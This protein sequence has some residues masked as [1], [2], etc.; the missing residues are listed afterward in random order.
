MLGHSSLALE[1]VE[2]L[3]EVSAVFVGIGGG[4]MAGGL[5]LGFNASRHAAK[6]YGIEP[7][8][9]PTMGE[10]LR[11]GHPVELDKTS[12]VADGL[13][14]PTAS[15][16]GYELTKSRFESVDTVEDAEIVAAMLLLMSRSK[17]Y[18]EPSGSAALAGLLKFRGRFNGSDQVVVLSPGATLTSKDSSRCSTL[19]RIRRFSSANTARCLLRHTVSRL[20]E[21]HRRV[22]PGVLED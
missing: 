12:S 20:P 8:G 13:A 2:R 16:L 4:G 19:A 18:A 10:S 6:L 9:A 21:D 22:P 15:E 1:I 7:S 14:A 5:A 17:L 3:P 11:R